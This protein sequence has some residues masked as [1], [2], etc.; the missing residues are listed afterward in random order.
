MADKGPE[1][2]FATLD[3]LA[4]RPAPA[5]AS[6]QQRSF[7]RRQRRLAAFL[8]GSALTAQNPS[9]PADSGSCIVGSRR[10]SHEPWC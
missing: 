10:T 1:L 4:N 8:E 5:S 2:P 3:N 7:G 9:R 6:G